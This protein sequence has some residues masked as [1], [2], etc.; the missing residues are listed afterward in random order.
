MP[1]IYFLQQWFNLSD[2]E[3]EDAIYD[4][5]SMRLN[6]TTRY[7]RAR[8]LNISLPKEWLRCSTHSETDGLEPEFFVRE[9]PVP[10][11]LIVCGAIARVSIDRERGADR[12]RDCPSKT[13][14]D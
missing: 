9:V 12:S 3:A 11:T 2:P 6:C 10:S 7:V 8:A 13:D 1:R 14:R 5:E 4:S